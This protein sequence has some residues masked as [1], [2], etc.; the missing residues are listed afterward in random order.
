MKKY[1]LVHI[2]LIQIIQLFPSTAHYLLSIAKIIPFVEVLIFL[3]S[4]EETRARFHFTHFAHFS[5]LSQ[6]EFPGFMVLIRVI[7]GSSV[8][9]D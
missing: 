8:Y 3:I 7:L 4:I 9:H 6:L 5:H 2:L 1:K